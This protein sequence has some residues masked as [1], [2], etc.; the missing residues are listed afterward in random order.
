MKAAVSYT[1]LDVYKRQLWVYEEPFNP[2]EGTSYSVS[3]TTVPKDTIRHTPAFSRLVIRNLKTA[4]AIHIDSV[5]NYTL[6]DKGRS[7]F[8]LR[9]QP[10][11]G[12]NALCYGCLL[13][14]SRTW[15]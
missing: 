4:K 12:G 1:H 3:T 5:S 13:Y 15:S 8:F 14:T 10:L 9:N 2:I 6:Y 7:I 11:S